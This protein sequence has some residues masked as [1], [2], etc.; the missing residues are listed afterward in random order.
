MDMQIWQ[1]YS[2]TDDPEIIA[3]FL[4]SAINCIKS[5]TLYITSCEIAPNDSR[6]IDLK[7]EYNRYT[8]RF[9][10]LRDEI[11]KLCVQNGIQ[12]FPNDPNLPFDLINSFSPQNN[13]ARLG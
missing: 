10:H 2:K 12:E 6:L 7:N 11:N 8:D 9:N 13:L 4:H 3:R 5:Y 1:L